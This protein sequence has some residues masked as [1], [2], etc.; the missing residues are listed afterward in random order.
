MDCILYLARKCIN[1]NVINKFVSSKSSKR[2][3]DLCVITCIYLKIYCFFEHII[4]VH[5]V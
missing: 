3:V 4:S 5:Y 2:V 1:L